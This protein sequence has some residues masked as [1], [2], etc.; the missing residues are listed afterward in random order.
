[1]GDGDLDQSKIGELPP[2]RTPVE[3]KV[4]GD[5]QRKKAYDVA[6]REVEA[7]RQ[8][9]VVYPLVAE[10]EK[11]DLSDAT[12]G[13]AEL[14]RVFQPHVVGLVHGQMKGEEKDAVMARFRAGEIAVPA[15]R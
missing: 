1:M 4:Y 7:G 12:S 8:V 6:R 3:T 9:Y 13:A 14:A 15:P 5:S 11:S 10:S 2:G